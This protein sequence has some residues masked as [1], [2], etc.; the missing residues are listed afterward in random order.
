MDPK[1]SQIGLGLPLERPL[2]DTPQKYSQMT[3]QGS[4]NDPQDAPKT[5]Q[6]GA[7]IDQKT[8]L[9]SN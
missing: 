2:R 6:N 8:C 5:L 3:P 9:K 4:P 7:E 1:S